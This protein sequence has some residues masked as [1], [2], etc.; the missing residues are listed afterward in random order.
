MCGYE[1]LEGVGTVCAMQ[2]EVAEASP[3]YQVPMPLEYH[4]GISMSAVDD[5]A[6]AASSRL[7]MKSRMAP[8]SFDASS[9]GHTCA[10]TSMMNFSIMNRLSFN[11]VKKCWN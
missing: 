5:M 9:S 1:D 4:K 10:I 8:S 3:R 11:M 6:A 2:G 7:Q